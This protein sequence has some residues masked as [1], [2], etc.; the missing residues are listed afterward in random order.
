[1]SRR[2]RRHCPGLVALTDSHRSRP[3][4]G[5]AQRV[6]QPRAVGRWSWPPQ[7]RSIIITELSCTAT[8]SPIGAYSSRSRCS[9]IQAAMTGCGRSCRQSARDHPLDW[10]APW[11]RPSFRTAAVARRAHQ[12]RAG[13]GRQ[14]ALAARRCATSTRDRRNAG[15]RSPDAPEYGKPF[16]KG[17]FSNWFRERCDEAGLKHCTAHGLR[18]RSLAGSPRTAPPRR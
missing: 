15:N 8:T 13:E 18:R 9:A 11:R 12:L 10:S 16:S 2:P 17:G 7:Y 3:P 14:G 1:M 6:K 5:W 4:N